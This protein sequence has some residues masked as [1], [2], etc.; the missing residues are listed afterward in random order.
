[1]SETIVV[2]G[3]RGFVG[4]HL[5]GKLLQSERDVRCGSRSP[6][7][8]AKQ[9]PDRTWV[10]LDVENA[11]SLEAAFSGASV[12]VYLVHQ[13]R[14]ES[15]DLEALEVASA[16]RVQEAAAQAGVRRIVYL[17]GPAPQG[18]VISAH[19]RARLATG[20]A[21]RSGSVST[22][23]LRAPMIVGDGSESWLI[24]RD[25]A[26]RLP[27][28]VLP[29]W[30]K[31]QSQPIAIDDVVAAIEA[32]C[33]LELEGSTWFDLPGPEVLSAREI[34]I[35][36]ASARGLSPWMLPVPFLT[37]SLSSHWIRWVTRADYKVARKLVDGL[38]DDLVA[39]GPEFWERLPHLD[40]TPF[41]I[42]V[43]RALA[44]EDPSDMAWRGWWL[45]RSVQ[46]VA[47]R[48]T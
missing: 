41:D 37:P 48:R 11:R 21:L 4:Q 26:M 10:A 2:C 19:L 6:D 7:Q 29:S 35:R 23:E 34:L 15:P 33:D 5:V 16:Q 27:L 22:V 32:A 25:L 44:S 42:A 30:L 3:A 38:T 13:M 20:E 46:A 47:G 17:G 8:A 43:K 45:E 39:T 9:W 36:V 14:T 28:M 31:S 18:P 1:M 24:V 12:V 40:R